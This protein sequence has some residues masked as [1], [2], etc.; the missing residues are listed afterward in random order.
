MG[1]APYTPSPNNIKRFFKDIQSLG[2]PP[3]VDRTYLPT[4]GFKSSNDR[5]LIVVAKDLG[6]IDANGIPTQIWY[7]FRDKD[8]APGV[9]ASAIK[10][11]YSDLFATYPDADKKDNK[12]LQNY[13]ASTSKVAVSVASYMV[14]TFKYLC[15][16]A[17]FK[18][19][20]VAKPATEPVKEPT[21][22]TVEK[23]IEG[24]PSAKGVT[25]NINI[26]LSLPATE[27]ASIYDKLF[28]ALKKHLFS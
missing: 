3:K 17:D 15:E 13:F 16:F 25:I 26:Q 9:M 4:I 18:A 2:I 12:A 22:P 5:Y 6:F 20:P 8:K 7:D 24:L 1:K 28:E 27:D 23:V 21:T 19:V 11:A 14:Q 10:I